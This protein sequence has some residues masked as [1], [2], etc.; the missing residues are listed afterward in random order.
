[1]VCEGMAC[2]APKSLGCQKNRPLIPR[3]PPPSPPFFVTF[4]ECPSFS[5]P[6]VCPSSITCESRP[7]LFLIAPGSTVP[8]AAKRCIPLHTK[9]VYFPGDTT[10]A[11]TRFP[12][13][14][15]R[16][17]HWVRAAARLARRRSVALR[18]WPDDAPHLPRLPNLPHLHVAMEPLLQGTNVAVDPA[19]VQPLLDESSWVEGEVAYPVDRRVYERHKEPFERWE[20]QLGCKVWDANA[21]PALSRLYK[22]THPAFGAAVCGWIVAEAER[23]AAAHGGWTRHR[24]DRYQGGGEVQMHFFA[25]F[26]TF[27]FEP[28]FALFAL[29]C[30]FLHLFPL[31]CQSCFRSFDVC[32]AARS[33]CAGTYE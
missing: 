18:F 13:R 29:F 10:P 3:P 28:F 6:M 2:E 5:P 20:R 19:Q 32:D 11:A 30:I 14:G 33:W 17:A 27:H 25:F 21:T 9:Q 8:R 4:S 1:M 15:A 24:H 16:L 31:P 12:H 7:Q 23:F 22:F 26:C